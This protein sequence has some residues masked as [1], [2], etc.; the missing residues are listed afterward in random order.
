MSKI[1][2]KPLVKLSLVDCTI[3][4]EIP[5]EPLSDLQ[6]K[7][8][9]ILKRG[10][11]K[12]SNLASKAGFDPYQWQQF[13]DCDSYDEFWNALQNMTKIV[14]KVQRVKKCNADPLEERWSDVYFL[15]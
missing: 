2:G 11:S 3:E 7:I 15:I 10:R 4:L 9:D 5:E 14:D 6:N 8:I 12:A 13:P 1:Y